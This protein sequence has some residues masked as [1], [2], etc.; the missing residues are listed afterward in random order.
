[1]KIKHSFTDRLF[2]IFCYFVVALIVIACIYPLWLVIKYIRTGVD[3]YNSGSWGIMAGY[4]DAKFAEFALQMEEVVNSD[5]ENTGENAIFVNV[6][7]MKNIHNFTVPNGNKLDFG[8]M[9]GT[10]DITYHNKNS[11]NHA[12]VGGW[13]GDI[14]DLLQYDEDTAGGLMSTEMVVVNENWSM[15]ECL[16]EMRMQAGEL[17][18][19]YY[20][21]VVDDDERLR[22]VFPLT[23][24][25][26]SPSVSK[27]MVNCLTVHNALRLRPPAGIVSGNSTAVIPS[28]DQPANV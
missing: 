21:Y 26:T 23:K 9:F 24:M 28:T 6:S 3:R 7:G 11:V 15:P 1:M 20:V 17:D 10:M 8:H 18:E 22:G 13:A 2:L 4:E 27:V 25:I 5:P 19:I 16:K 12:D 14:V